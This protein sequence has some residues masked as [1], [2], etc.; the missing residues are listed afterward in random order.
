MSENNK[1]ETTDKGDDFFFVRLARIILVMLFLV[2]VFLPFIGGWRHGEAY[3]NESVWVSG[4]W[5]LK[6]ESYTFGLLLVCFVIFYLFG[7]NRGIELIIGKQDE[8]IKFTS[9]VL[10]LI[11]LFYFISAIFFGTIAHYF[12]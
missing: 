11:P 4:L 7:G 1:I 12:R 6:F 2:A 5:V 8:M 9:P 10:P 3:P